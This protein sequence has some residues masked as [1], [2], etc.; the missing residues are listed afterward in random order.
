MRATWTV[1]I[2]LHTHSL[3][4]S[5]SHTSYQGFAHGT[6]LVERCWLVPMYLDEWI[7][8]LAI[9]FET[10]FGPTPVRMLLNTLVSQRPDVCRDVAHLASHILR[11]VRSAQAASL[12]ITYNRCGMVVTRNDGPSLWLEINNVVIYCTITANSLHAS[13][14]HITQGV[15]AEVRLGK[16][17]CLLTCHRVSLS[18]ACKE[19][20]I[21]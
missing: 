3:R 2:S 7:H 20:E 17:L 4:H 9:S 21:E 11:H 13:H 10:D 14:R 8:T 1:W 16:S 12:R 18:Y 5:H 19:Q 6:I 15:R